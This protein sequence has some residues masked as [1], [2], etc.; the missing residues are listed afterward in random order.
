MDPVETLAQFVVHGYGVIIAFVI[1][2]ILPRGNTLRKMQLYIF[3]KL[4]D[5][6]AFEEER[7]QKRVTDTK[8]KLRK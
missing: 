7:L 1:G 8:A 3:T 6:F 5:Y 4:H 2:W